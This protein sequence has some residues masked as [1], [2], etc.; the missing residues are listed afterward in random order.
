MA[1]V[2]RTC[3]GIAAIVQEADDRLTQV[4]T[5]EVCDAAIIGATRRIE[6]YEIAAYGCARAYAV[7]V[8]RTDEAR[9]LQE[10]LNEQGRADRG[11]AAL[12]GSEPDDG[13]RPAPSRAERSVSEPRSAAADR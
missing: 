2:P 1:A 11:L 12:D 6:H 8:N 9:L 10:T 4:T 13:P 3:A 5:R 7:R